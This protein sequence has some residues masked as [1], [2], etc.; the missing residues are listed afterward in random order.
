[1]AAVNPSL[2]PKPPVRPPDGG[3]RPATPGHPTGGNPFDMTGIGFPG[4]TAYIDL[5]TSV[6]VSIGALVWIF[7]TIEIDAL[8]D[9]LSWRLIIILVPGL[10][11]YGAIALVI[12]AAS[13]LWLLDP[14]PEDFGAW[15]AAR[16]KCASYLLGIVNYALGAAALT[17]LLRRRAG[18]GLGEAASIVLLVSSLDMVIVLGFASIGAALG[19]AGAPGVRLGIVAGAAISL[20]GGMTL[21]R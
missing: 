18:T 3:S 2:A 15:T 12:E 20:F 7:S 17:I 16:I 9:A 11:L 8:V 13:I 5:Q 14:V 21:L 1:M 19:Q 10:L 4:C 6:L